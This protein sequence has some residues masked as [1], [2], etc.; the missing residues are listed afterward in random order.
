MANQNIKV[1]TFSSMPELA[2]EG[3]DPNAVD[4]SG[5]HT[6]RARALYAA[7][8]ASPDDLEYALAAHADGRWALIGLTV[9]GHD[10]AV[11]TEA[12]SDT[13]PYAASLSA[14]V[15]VSS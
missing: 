5:Y 9:T 4:A 15:E 11:E 2:T 6:A 13:E 7:L 14:A 3:W 8:G 12:S 1:L 10:Y